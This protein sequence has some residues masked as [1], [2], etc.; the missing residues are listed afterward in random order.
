MVETNDGFK[1]ADV[2]LRL[3]GPGDIE[4]TQQSGI[5]FDLK[6]A[7]IVNDT[8][9]LKHARNTASD[10]LNDDPNL[11][12]PENTILNKQL[13]ILFARTKNWGVVS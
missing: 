1:I 2:D 13:K 10:I 4:G 5:A 3:R 7:N 6:I 12:K 11:E 8:D 9:I